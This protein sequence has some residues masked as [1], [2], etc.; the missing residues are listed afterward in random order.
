[1]HACLLVVVAATSSA[2][3]DVSDL[4]SPVLSAVRVPP[5][6]IQYLRNGGE[7][8]ER[9]TSSKAKVSVICAVLM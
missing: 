9:E 2:A 7:R 3:V 1:M 6:H 4:V 8:G 5:G